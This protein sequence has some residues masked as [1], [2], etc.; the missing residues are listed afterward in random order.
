[1][2]TLTLAV[3]ADDLS[4]A[5]ECASHALLRVSRSTV[6]LSPA[7]DGERTRLAPRGADEPAHSV[8][9]VDTDS[10]RLGAPDAVRA[11]RAAAPLVAPAEVVV[12]KVD[13]LLRGHVGAEVAALADALQRTPVV[14]LA[15]PA[16]Q[17]VVHD[18]ILRVA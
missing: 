12:K 16:L 6:V 1:M 4:G 5:A 17:R 18:G 14:A 11:V 8:L 10:R 7:T 2:T 13:S 15:N 3:V 9:T